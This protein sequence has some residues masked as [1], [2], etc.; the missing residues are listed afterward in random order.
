[1]IWWCVRGRAGQLAWQ[2]GR[3]GSLPTGRE[4]G[5]REALGELCLP[6]QPP[7]RLRVVDPLPSPLL[8]LEPVSIEVGYV[9]LVEMV[10]R[11]CTVYRCNE[12]GYR[13]VHARCL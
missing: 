10:R 9:E 5:K 8:A 13:A 1:M 3:A 7:D 4:R 6:L 11:C 2:G 12:L